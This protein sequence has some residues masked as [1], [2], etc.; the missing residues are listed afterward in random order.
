LDLK[1]IHDIVRFYLN[2]E[3]GGWFAPEELDDLLDRAQWWFYSEQYDIYARTQKI[4]D[5]L[6]VFSTPFSYTSTA[7]GVVSLPVDPKINPCYEHLLSIHCQYYDNINQKTRY[8]AIKIINEDELAGRLDA[9]ILAPTLQHPVGVVTTVEGE[10]AKLGTIQLYPEAEITGKGFYLRRP[11]KPKF[12]YTMTGR[13][14]T[15]NDN[16][17]VQMEWNE[18]SMN[19]IIIKALQIAGVNIT[20]QMIIEYTELKN[21]QNI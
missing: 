9:Q 10:S 19:K 21:A 7:N 6:S 20:D 3:Q 12:V 1:I 16:T 2:K 11:L 15:Y 13:E 4:T 17:S 8:R 14:I 5:A 18:T